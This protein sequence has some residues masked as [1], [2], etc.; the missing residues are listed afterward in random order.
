MRGV[1]VSW[2]ERAACNYHWHL[3]GLPTRGLGFPDNY[4]VAGSDAILLW[5]HL[6]GA[7]SETG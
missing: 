4:H 7:C 3:W 5:C 1:G 6:D 2:E